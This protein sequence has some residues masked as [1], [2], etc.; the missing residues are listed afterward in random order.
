[1]GDNCRI[2]ANI[3]RYTCI[4]GGVQTVSGTHPTADW[5]SLHPAFFSDNCQ[6][7]FSY[8]DR[9]L[10]DENTGVVAI[11]SD[12]WIG[13]NALLLNGV[14]VGDG[15]VIAAGAVVTKDVPPYTIVG[16]IPAKPIRTR[17]SPEEID[18][19]LR[20][21]W[22]EKPK[23]W[24]AEHAAEFADIHAFYENHHD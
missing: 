13:Q 3:G 9:P 8:T 18:F 15:A 23:E 22:W 1:M 6:A 19:L 17:F 2:H 14:T 10:F 20:F 11:G 7:G 21:K 5:V 12:V 4:A 16:G 24:I